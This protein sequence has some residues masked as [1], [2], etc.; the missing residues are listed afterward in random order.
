MCIQT[1]LFDILII[2]I[3][4]TTQFKFL[5]LF[6]NG[7]KEREIE[8]YRFSIFLFSVFSSYL[9][10]L[11]LCSHCLTAFHYCLHHSSHLEQTSNHAHCLIRALPEMC[12]PCTLKAAPSRPSPPLSRLQPTLRPNTHCPTIFSKDCKNTIL[13][14]SLFGNQEWSYL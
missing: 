8:I 14:C 11:A 9:C 5:H 2:D 6:G 4:I 13:F 1:A 7:V 3:L 12:I 10:S